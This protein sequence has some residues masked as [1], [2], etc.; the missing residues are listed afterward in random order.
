M[1]AV[2]PNAAVSAQNVEERQ[3]GF[4]SST[5][6]GDASI[7]ECSFVVLSQC[8]DDFDSCE[9]W[10]QVRERDNHKTAYI[11]TCNMLDPLRSIPFFEHRRAWGWQRRVTAV[12]G[13]LRPALEKS[14]DAQ[15]QLFP[16]ARLNVISKEYL[17]KRKLSQ[18]YQDRLLLELIAK[19]PCKEVAFAACVEGLSA[20]SVEFLPNR[21]FEVDIYSLSGFE[22]YLQALVAAAKT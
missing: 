2:V 18:E 4:Q 14:S 9:S 5:K 3:L 20:E 1:G 19:H 7:S 15:F 22:A 21:P 11:M 10:W 16:Y 13:D 17:G 12:V 6:V 8:I